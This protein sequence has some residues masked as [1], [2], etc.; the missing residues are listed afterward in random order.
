MS[1]KSI[2]PPLRGGG[3][4]YRDDGE[5][6]SRRLKVGQKVTPVQ[7]NKPDEQTLQ[8][9]RS[10]FLSCHGTYALVRGSTRRFGSIN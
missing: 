5:R 1:S 10:Y 8:S 6:S 4:L 9:V 3:S 7:V 2:V